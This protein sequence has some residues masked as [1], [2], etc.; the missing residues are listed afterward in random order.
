MEYPINEP[1]NSGSN[2]NQL[3]YILKKTDK[4]REPKTIYTDDDSLDWVELDGY[5]YSACG[6]TNSNDTYCWGN[7][8][9]VEVTTKE[10]PYKIDI[11]AKKVTIS[12]NGTCIL[13]LSDN[14]VHC[15]GWNSI[16]TRFFGESETNT[17]TFRERPLQDKYVS[18][19]T[20]E[21]DNVIIKDIQSYTGSTCLI[22]SENIVYCWGKG[23][24]G[25]LGNGEAPSNSLP[26]KVMDTYDT[27]YEFND[28]I[29]FSGGGS[30]P[31]VQSGAGNLLCWGTYKYDISGTPYRDSNDLSSPYYINKNPT[32]LSN[33]S[34]WP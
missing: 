17:D 23:S 11:K 20:Q 3:G 27:P 26:V 34:Q 2:N 33:P 22:T 4:P 16:S 15:W 1:A 21:F 9:G 29:A 7:N 12:N 13:A 31:C 10:L 18:N 19:E 30:T 25:Q 8:H 14:K 32:T 24:Y 28:F 5:A 6:I